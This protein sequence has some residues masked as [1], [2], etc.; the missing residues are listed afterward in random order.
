MD[1]PNRG[2]SDVDGVPR[3][4][5]PGQQDGV[6]HPIDAILDGLGVATP[7]EDHLGGGRGDPCFVYSWF[8]QSADLFS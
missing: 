2:P 1:G 6:E 5:G 8:I 7:A 3:L 4:G